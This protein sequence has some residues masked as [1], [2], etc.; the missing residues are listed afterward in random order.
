MITQSIMLEA[1]HHTYTHI[2]THTQNHNN[3]KQKLKVSKS[4]TIEHDGPPEV[5]VAHTN[6]Q[7]NA[8]QISVL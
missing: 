8:D 5:L 3:D 2:H 7:S 6:T 4:I 1:R